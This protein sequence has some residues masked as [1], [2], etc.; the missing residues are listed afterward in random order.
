M[1]PE[2]GREATGK[3]LLGF[4]GWLG[5][6]RVNRSVE[7]PGKPCRVRAEAINVRREDITAGRPCGESER[8]IV[9]QKSGN[10][11]GAKGPC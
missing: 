4:P 9:A 3:H 8:P 2:T 6:A 10:A 5:A 7:E 11:D 1:K